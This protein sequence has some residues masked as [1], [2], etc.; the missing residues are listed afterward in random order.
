MLIAEL[1]PH[2]VARLSRLVR[3]RQRRRTELWSATELLVLLGGLA[4]G[5]VILLGAWIG[6]SGT[7]RYSSLVGWAAFGVAAPAVAGVAAAS[8][9]LSGIKTIRRETA[10]MGARVTELAAGRDN[11]ES[12]PIQARRAVPTILS[13]EEFVASKGMTRFHR[14]DCLMVSGKPVTAASVLAHRSAGRVPCG[15]CLPSC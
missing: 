12:A 8:W 9:I 10:E 11:G 1:G 14:P 7:S 4:A 2:D 13:S 6:A 3:Q 15:M 5:A